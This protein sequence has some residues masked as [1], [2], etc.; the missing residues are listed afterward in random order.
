MK[1][2]NLVISALIC[3]TAGSALGATPESRSTN[4][5]TV[6]AQ[7]TT[8]TPSPNALDTQD[9]F[10]DRERERSHDEIRERLGDRSPGPTTTGQGFAAPT[11]NDKSDVPSVGPRSNQNRDR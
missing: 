1:L 11:T 6:L 8:P 3:L 5:S 9:Q 2:E 4:R 7:L 10:R